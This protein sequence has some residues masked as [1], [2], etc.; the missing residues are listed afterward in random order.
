MLVFVVAA[1]CI[2]QAPLNEKPLTEAERIAKLKVLLAPIHLTEP[3]APIVKAALEAPVTLSFDQTPLPEVVNRL[4]PLLGGN[5][6]L[7]RYVP[8]K[9]E[10]GKAIPAPMITYR[11]VNVPLKT[12]LEEMLATAG[13]DY[14]FVHEGIEVSDR[15]NCRKVDEWRLYPVPDILAMIGA[16]NGVH[17]IR[18]ITETVDSEGWLCNGGDGEIQTAPG[19]ALLVKCGAPTHR[20]VAQFLATLRWFLRPRLV[21]CDLGVL[22]LGDPPPAAKSDTILLHRNDFFLPRLAK[23]LR[24]RHDFDIRSASVS[25]AVKAVERT[26]GVRMK[27][28]YRE[29]FRDAE[30]DMDDL[31]NRRIT[32]VRRGISA[33]TALDLLREQGLHCIDTAEGLTVNFGYSERVSEVPYTWRYYPTGVLITAM[34]RP[35]LK[36]D[37]NQYLLYLV[38]DFGDN[39][40]PCFNQY[41]EMIVVDW[42]GF[43]GHLYWGPRIEHRR[44]EQLYAGLRE[45][46]RRR[47]EILKLAGLPS[48]N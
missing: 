2:G 9:N 47:A 7:D 32:I 12:A 38:A 23:E 27:V 43:T 36:S 16:E 41:P 42:L 26:I 17:I 35:E 18:A 29:L 46:V 21:T 28:D 34:N 15:D 19:G 11:C 13:L 3:V 40:I 48:K 33:R 8:D 14:R 30:A 22:D 45:A 31:R 39:T 37:V 5:I 4:S 25:D 1:A 6:Q 10:D 44:F 24:R 20:L